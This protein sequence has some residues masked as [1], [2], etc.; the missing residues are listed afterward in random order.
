MLGLGPGTVHDVEGG[1]VVDL[2][3]LLLLQVV[4]VL[5]PVTD[6]VEGGTGLPGIVQDIDHG[7]IVND[8]VREIVEVGT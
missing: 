8:L 3:L 4:V 6:V 2:V 7:L 5:V 1:T